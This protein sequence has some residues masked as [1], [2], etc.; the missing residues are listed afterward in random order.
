[1]KK[2]STFTRREFIA[3]TSAFVIASQLHGQSGASDA[4][5]LALNGGPK[6]VKTPVGKLVRWGDLERDQLIEAIKQDNLLFWNGPQTALLTKRFQEHHPLKHVMTCTSGTAAVHIAVA[7]AGVGPGDEVITT[8]FT[9]PGTV[10]GI[11][12]QQGV[13]VFAD[14]D[15]ENYMVTPESAAKCITSKTKAIIAVHLSGNPSR[16]KEL[17]ALADKHKLVL[18]EDCAQAWGAL[19]QGKP[20][21][22]IGHV[23]TFSLQQS[24]HVTCGD[25]GVVASNDDRI[26]PKL[27]RFGDKGIDRGDRSIKRERLATNY[28][29]SELLAA[30]TAA[31]LTRL[32]GIAEKRAKLGDLLSAELSGVKGLN[33]PRV[34]AGNRCTYWNYLLRLKLKELRCSRADFV[35]AMAAEG[36]SAGAG[37]IPELL[38]EE[39]VFRNHAF[40]EGRWP[41]KEMGLTTMDYSKV[42]LA[43]AEA[44]RD[45]VLNMRVHEAMSEENVREMALGIRKVAKYYAA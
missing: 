2:R 1:M 22:T 18:I 14:L 8:G 24:K 31:Q 11:L 38:H 6:A 40:F 17:K 33:P 5:K 43:E 3:S 15:P 27:R 19:Y 35:K 21:G 42:R 10:I 4:D 37:Y 23:A 7:A 12:Y 26:G 20:V 25:G 34:D 28:R 30:F 41:V 9:D 16:L 36:V 32:N 29:M 39:P 13:P 45:S 44:I